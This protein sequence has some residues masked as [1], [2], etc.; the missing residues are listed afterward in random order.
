MNGYS[1]F[2]CKKREGGFK[3]PPEYSGELL[4]INPNQVNDN[5]GAIVKLAC[6]SRQHSQD[7]N[8]NW[9]KNNN[10][11]QMGNHIFAYENILIIRSATIEDSGEYKCEA[12]INDYVY[13]STAIV[14]IN[15]ALI[16]R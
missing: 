2:E 9:F 3:Q 7:L 13:T 6:Q 10:N 16:R 11:I 15:G 4:F 12:A 1:G 14:N 5:E 8:Y